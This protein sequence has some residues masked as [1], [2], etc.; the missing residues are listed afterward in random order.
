MGKREAEVSEQQ[1]DLTDHCFIEDDRDLQ[2]KECGPTLEA[3][4]GQK[5]DYPLEVPERNVAMLTLVF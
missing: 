3:E 2:T 5:T 1:K 4:R